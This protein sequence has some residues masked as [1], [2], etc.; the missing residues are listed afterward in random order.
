MSVG[1]H[2]LCVQQERRPLSQGHDQVAAACVRSL[3]E[4]HGSAEKPQCVAPV[5]SY[6]RESAN[7]A[8]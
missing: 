6:P 1:G 7:P 5:V 4:V 2:L 8:P 3:A